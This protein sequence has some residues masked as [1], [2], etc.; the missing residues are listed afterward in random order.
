VTA[1]EGI[2][3]TGESRANVDDW[4]IY[5]DYHAT[6]PV[7]P[8][9]ASVVMHHM[10]SAY[11][12]AHSAD[13]VFG[14]AASQAIDDSIA[15]LRRLVSAPLGRVIWT[16]GATEAIN[17]AIKGFIATSDS[18]RPVRIV[19]SPTEHSA[20]LGT[21]YALRQA[22]LATTRLLGV[23][24]LGRVDLD[25]IESICRDGAD[26]LCVMAANNE[27]GTIAPIDQIAAISNRYGVAFLCDATQAIGRITLDLERDS[28][29]FLVL[30]GHKMY[31]PK[32]VG[33]LICGSHRALTPLIHG[34]E[35][36][37]GLRAGTLNVPGIVGV[38]EA[39]R[40]RR[41]EMIQDEA[42][43]AV[44]RDRLQAQLEAE[45]HGL[46]VNGNIDARLAGNLHISIPDV[47][48]GA[49]IARVRHRLAIATGAACS[50]GIEG[51]SHVLRAIKL[52]RGVADGALRISIGKFTTD[53]EVDE[54]VGL[55]SAAVRSA[56]SSL[57]INQ[58]PARA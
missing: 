43:I 16:S 1:H 38:G 31:A 49:V 57:R 14:D 35:Q 10:T 40:L 20:V 2:A 50:S 12:N 8:R 37:G 13:H 29:A 47:P 3:L 26:M 5:M 18:G 33:A 22:G 21:C 44:R 34:G 28:I 25:E 24:A 36:Q 56:R 53:A 52:P 58:A 30:S 9:V 46:L 17:L 11:G 48:N 27:V 7:D 19:V 41:V 15:E 45:V 6:T 54:A 39:S 32:G 4:P 42:E 55:L 51:P 23:D